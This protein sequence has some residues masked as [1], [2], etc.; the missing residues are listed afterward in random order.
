MENALQR[1]DLSVKA[2]ERKAVLT[3]SPE[4]A[5]EESSTHQAKLQQ[6]CAELLRAGDAR[7]LRML[8]SVAH[9]V[10]NH[11]NAID[12]LATCLMNAADLKTS[13]EDLAVL[14]ANAHDIDALIDR[15]LDFENLLLGEEKLALEWLS[16]ADLHRDVAFVL[17]KMASAKKLNFDGTVEEGLAQVVSDRL[18]LREIVLNLGTNAVKYTRFGSVSLRFARHGAECWMLEVDDTGPGI[19]LHS[20]EKIFEDFQRLPETCTG[21]PGAGLGLAIVRRLVQMLNGRIELESE[22]GSGT[23]FQVILPTQ[24]A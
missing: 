7:R 23:S 15:L 3:P 5:P 2:E 9:E 14:A 17:R 24:Y 18:K 20:R 21:Q 16:L 6:G 12:L 10:R 13:G 1:Q 22:V 8:R 11:V 19:P 4:L